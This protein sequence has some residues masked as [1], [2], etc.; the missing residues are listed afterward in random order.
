VKRALALAGLVLAG[1]GCYAV[2]GPPGIDEPVR[3]EVVHNLGRLPQAQAYLQSAVGDALVDR[4]GW[5][6]SPNGS[7]RLEL[8]LLREQI[9]PAARDSRGITTRWVIRLR[10]KALLVSQKGNIMESFSGV[11]YATALTDEDE[12]LQ[13]AAQNAAFT[14]TSWLETET[15]KLK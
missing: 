15:K 14:L 7:A 9:D 3:V 10:G 5:R 13:V 2:R 12:A 1:A 4:L 8:D 6:V 11:G